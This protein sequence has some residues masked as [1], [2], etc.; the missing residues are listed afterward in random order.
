MKKNNVLTLETLG[1]VLEEFSA[2]AENSLGSNNAK[3]QY[4]E[5]YR[6]EIT[7]NH[8]RNVMFKGMDKDMQDSFYESMF[9][10]MV[11]PFDDYMEYKK[12]R[13]ESCKDGNR[14][15]H[16]N[17]IFSFPFIVSPAGLLCDLAHLY[18]TMLTKRYKFNAWD[19]FNYKFMSIYRPSICARI[20]TL[21]EEK[22]N[23]EWEKYI[24]KNAQV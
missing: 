2:L 16:A 19:E 18:Q 11:A 24:E 21:S 17:V 9:D 1:E 5:S 22:R 4:T 7:L 23:E 6:V 14:H 10:R 20:Y 3:I 8:P 15:L 12:V 13:Y